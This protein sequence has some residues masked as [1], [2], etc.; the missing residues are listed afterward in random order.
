MNT[1]VDLIAVSRD[2]VQREV[3]NYDALVV[4]AYSPLSASLEKLALP[5]G[6][7]AAIHA[8]MNSD[9]AFAKGAQGP[10]VFPAAGVCGGRLILAT[11][12]TLADDV[13]DVRLIAECVS[14]AIFAGNC[15]WI[16]ATLARGGLSRRRAFYSRSRCGGARGDG[17]TVAG[18]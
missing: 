15:C 3:N 4:V 2:H 7:A 8:V 6:G 13:D 16:S 17:D 18:R 12:N 1:P 14:L 5:E 9:R 11:M 10:A